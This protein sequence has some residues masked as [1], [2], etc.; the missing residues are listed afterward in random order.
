MY[1]LYKLTF[2]NGKLYIGITSNFNRRMSQHK[3]DATKKDLKLYRAINKYGWNNI[4]KEVVIFG[5]TRFE[6]MDMEKLLIAEQDLVRAGYNTTPGGELISEHCHTEMIK[7]MS[8]PE[9]REKCVRALK[10]KEK[11]RIA[12]LGSPETRALN[13]AAQKRRYLDGK[14]KLPNTSKPII[15]VETGIVYSSA[16]EAARAMNLN[17]RLIRRVASGERNHHNGFTF[18]FI[19]EEYNVAS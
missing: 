9:Y 8:N 16:A 1:S 15:C 2:P 5:L 18:K 7:R 4:K 14:C 3:H 17:G 12:K 11:E 6:A 19:N 10:S 13:S